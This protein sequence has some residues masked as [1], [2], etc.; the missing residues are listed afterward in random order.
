MSSRLQRLK[1]RMEKSSDAQTVQAMQAHYKTFSDKLA[2]VAQA[3]ISG[4]IIDEHIRGRVSEGR[5]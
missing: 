1:W 4:T 2:V 5:L 3:L